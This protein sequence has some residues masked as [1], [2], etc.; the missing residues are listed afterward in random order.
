M[1]NT[2]Q[3]DVL[4]F[5]EPDQVMEVLERQAK[6]IRY[7]SI[8]GGQGTEDISELKFNLVYYNTFL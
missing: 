5:L 6:M 8:R 1:Q 7:K 3:E 4:C 2:S